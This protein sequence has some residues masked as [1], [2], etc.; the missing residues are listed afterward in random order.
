MALDSENVRR[1]EIVM[2]KETL[3]K[4]CQPMPAYAIHSSRKFGHRVLCDLF[5]VCPQ[6]ILIVHSLS[7]N[8]CPF[9]SAQ[10]YG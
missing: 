6:K 10:N 2:G 1:I 8:N 7:S 5:S 9:F 4:L 3:A